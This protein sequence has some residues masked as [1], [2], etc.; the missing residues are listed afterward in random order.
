MISL[1]IYSLSKDYIVNYNQQTRKYN[2]KSNKIFSIK[3]NDIL[4]NILGM[5]QEYINTN[6]VES[7]TIC[8]LFYANFYINV[9]CLMPEILTSNN[10]WYNYLIPIKKFQ[11]NIVN[12]F[13]YKK[14]N[15]INETYCFLNNIKINYID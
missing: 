5:H 6:S 3:F 4:A 10:K 11:E 8:N 15:Q 2:I 14:A 9:D 7:Y 12:N 1:N 13:D